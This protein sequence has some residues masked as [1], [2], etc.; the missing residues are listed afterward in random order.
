VKP[1]FLLGCY[2]FIFH[3]SRNLA[4]LRNFGWGV[5]TPLRYATDWGYRSMSSFWGKKETWLCGRYVNM[6]LHYRYEKAAPVYITAMYTC[7][8]NDDNNQTPSSPSCLLQYSILSRT[9]WLTFSQFI[10]S[11]TTSRCEMRM[12]RGDYRGVC[13]KG[14]SYSLWATTGTWR[15]SLT[16]LI[17][18]KFA[19]CLMAHRLSTNALAHQHATLNSHTVQQL[20]CA[21]CIIRVNVYRLWNVTGFGFTQTLT[22]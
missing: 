19:Y 20:K 3:V 16:V 12:G 18:T 7:C 21:I 5:W 10:T 4:Q 1:V 17:V 14:K 2:G 15:R 9:R 6:T 11:Q 13:W 8:N 22:L